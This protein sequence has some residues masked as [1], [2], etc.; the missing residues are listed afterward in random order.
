[1][2]RYVVATRRDQRDS[3]DVATALD[4]IRGEPGIQVVGAADPHMVT[5]EASDEDAG[6]LREK[7]AGTHFVEAEIRRG[8]H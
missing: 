7:L 6:R 5:I 3:G 1:M 8:L 2:A 4:A